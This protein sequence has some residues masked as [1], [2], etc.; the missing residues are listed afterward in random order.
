MAKRMCD[1]SFNARNDDVNFSSDGPVTNRSK[2]ARRAVLKCVARDV[3]KQLNDV[4]SKA[5]FSL[6]PSNT[7][8]NV[9]STSSTEVRH[10]PLHSS[11]FQDFSS[12]VNSDNDLPVDLE[13]RDFPCSDEDDDVSSYCS[14][15]NGSDSGEDDGPFYCNIDNGSDTFQSSLIKFLDGCKELSLKD[16]LLSWAL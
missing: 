16:Q 11:I 10:S 14:F 2:Y 3:D 6:N 12:E 5:T 8:V 13:D 15:D 4:Y 7:A 1:D 9:A